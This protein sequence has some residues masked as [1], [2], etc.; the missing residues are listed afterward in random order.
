MSRN[1]IESVTCPGCGK[2]ADFTVWDS[3]NITLDPDLREKVLTGDLFKFTCP[4]CGHTTIVNY[5]VLYH[6]M[7][8]KIMIYFVMSEEGYQAAYDACTFSGFPETE[9][10]KD[11]L[12]SFQENTHD[13]L[14]RI[15]FTQ[16]SLREKINI[17]DRGK[18]DRILELMKVFMGGSLQKQQ[19]D[20]MAFSLY[21]G[22][23]FNEEFC[24]VL[25]KDGILGTVKL[26]QD[27]YD[28]LSESLKD[29]LPDIKDRKTLL[30]NSE[31]AVEFMK[32]MDE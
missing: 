24:V 8:N 4:E 2:E 25:G 26:P 23:D 12:K 15:V 21:Y 9:D 28:Q 14:Y 18:D 7:E 31:W 29:K 11:I 16:N 13:Y 27:M 1:H 30:I 17:F 5:P 32:S 22:Y 20:L 3:V 10:N 19:P 6:D